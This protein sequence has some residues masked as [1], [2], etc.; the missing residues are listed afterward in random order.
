MS[1]SMTAQS[2]PYLVD[3]SISMEK[4]SKQI[5]R[6]YTGRQIVHCS[7]GYNTPVVDMVKKRVNQIRASIVMFQRQSSG[8]SAVDSGPP[9]RSSRNNTTPKPFHFCHCIAELS[10][11][12]QFCQTPERV[13]E[14]IA[15]CSRRIIKAPGEW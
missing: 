13:L 8:I 5:T 15:N 14:S 10:A 2:C 7:I 6:E 4:E 1:R 11:K 9:L 3:E 12:D